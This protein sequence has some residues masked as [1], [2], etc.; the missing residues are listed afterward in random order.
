MPCMNPGQ[1]HGADPAAC[2]LVSVSV[3]VY[4]SVRASLHYTEAGLR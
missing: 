3:S 1:V 4:Y 2:G